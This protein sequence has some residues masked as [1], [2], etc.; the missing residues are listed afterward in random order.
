MKTTWNSK[1]NFE[2]RTQWAQDE[3]SEINFN[4]GFW[5]IKNDIDS[6]LAHGSNF[7]TNVSNKEM[8]A[9]CKHT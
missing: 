4:D 5:L 3:M 7:G 2:T 1:K 8:H 9:K 6:I